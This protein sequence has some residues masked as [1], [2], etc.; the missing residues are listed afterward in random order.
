MMRLWC[1]KISIGTWRWAKTRLQAALDGTKEIGFAVVA[2][3]V[4]LVAVFVPV[5]FLTGTVG[6][7]FNEFGISIAVAV[8]ISS[9][10]ALSL[11]P[12]LCSRIL[13]PLRGGDDAGWASRSFDA[14]FDG[15]SRVYEKNTQLCDAGALVDDLGWRC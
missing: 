14:F 4:A 8:I 6:R 5:A 10:V 15:L 9:F 11:S 7:L 2:T 13:R 1:W 3:T 12:M